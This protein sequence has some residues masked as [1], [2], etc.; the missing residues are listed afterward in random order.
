MIDSDATLNFINSSFVTNKGL[1]AVVHGGFEVKVAGGTLLPCTRDPM[2]KNFH[3][4]L[5]LDR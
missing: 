5:Y 2:A 3:G 1:H 4:K